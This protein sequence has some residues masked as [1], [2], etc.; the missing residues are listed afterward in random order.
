MTLLPDY[1]NK[2]RS[3]RD[4]VNIVKQVNINPWVHIQP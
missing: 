1:G 3:I 4:A 2:Q